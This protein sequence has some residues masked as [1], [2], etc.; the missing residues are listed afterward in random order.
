MNATEAKEKITIDYLD[1]IDSLVFVL[2][3]LKLCAENEM[4]FIEDKL[5]TRGFEHTFF[6]V[7][8]LNQVN[9]NRNETVEEGRKKILLDARNRLRNKTKFGDAGIVPVNAYY[10]EQGRVNKDAAQEKDSGI[11]QFEQQ[12]AQFLTQDRGKVKLSQPTKELKNTILDTLVNI[13]PNQYKLNDAS[14]E[15][16]TKKYNEVKPKLDL[17]EAKRKQ[18]TTK[19]NNRIADRE[20]DL[21]RF[22]EAR[23]RQISNNLYSYIDQIEVEKKLSLIPWKT[24]DSAKAMVEE[25]VE[26][27]Q[28]LIAEEQKEWIKSD[29]E[30]YIERLTDTFNDDFETHLKVICS[31]IDEL[32][33][34]ISTEVEGAP[35]TFD[36][37]MG[38][39]LGVLCQDFVMGTV[40]G[41]LGWKSAL[42]NLGIQAGLLAG[43]LLVG[44]TNPVTIIPVLIA[45]GL[46]QLFIGA[47]GF[48]KKIITKAKPQ[49]KEAFDAKIPTEVVKCTD[50]ILQNFYNQTQAVGSAIDSEIQVIKEQFEAAIQE[51]KNAEH[52]AEERKAVIMSCETELKNT[53]KGVDD[54]NDYLLSI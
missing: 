34:S 17:L 30:P 50:K 42:G 23:F 47:N 39:A 8:R 52:S 13:I 29:L 28:P 32:K 11:I 3:A 38:V 43:M 48:S 53:L 41:A 10:A 49:I 35:S 9:G 16:V 6:I 5:Q 2:S 4:R 45:S 18:V 14:L 7:N 22:F 54:I 27:L 25:L 33:L 24:K 36:K 15:A 40:G 20:Q 31:E 37:V 1:K 26:K 51:K 21:N 19:M 44:I 46:I 12:L